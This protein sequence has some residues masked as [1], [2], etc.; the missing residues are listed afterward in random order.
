MFLVA[1]LAQR[2]SRLV[3]TQNAVV[4]SL[5]SIASGFVQA[6]QRL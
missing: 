2:A 1:G 6:A 5:T 3:A 4:P